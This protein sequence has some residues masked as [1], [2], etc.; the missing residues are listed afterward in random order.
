MPNHQSQITSHK[1]LR[2]GLSGSAFVYVMPRELAEVSIIAAQRDRATQFDDRQNRM[3]VEFMRD[4]MRVMNG[5]GMIESMECYH[6]LSWDKEAVLDVVLDNPNVEFWSVHAP[7]GRH[8]DPSSPDEES[9]AGALAG[10]AD[11]VDVAR[12]LGAKIVVAHPGADVAY[13]APRERRLEFAAETLKEAADLAGEAGIRLAVEPLPLSEI[14]NTLDEVFWILDRIDRPNVGINF[15]TNHLFP[16]EAIPDLIRRVGPRLL[17]V[18]ISDQDGVER[19]WLPFEGT[20]DW[21]AVLTVLDE[22]GYSGPLVYEP[23]IHDVENCEDVGRI[24]VENYTRL[25]GLRSRF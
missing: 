20:M 12:R 6:S 5:Y 18:H 21:R 25:M 22:L 8:F 2:L 9:R 15:D 7:Y 19:H 23:H 13:D 14:G 16:P 24:V 10:F 17:S 4:M 3:M 1:S 11:A